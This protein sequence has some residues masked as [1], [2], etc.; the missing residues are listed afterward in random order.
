MNQWEEG[1]AYLGGVCDLWLG[2]VSDIV[3]AT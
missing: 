1:W 2:I 3:S